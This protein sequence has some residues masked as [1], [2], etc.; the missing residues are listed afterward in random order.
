MALIAAAALAAPVAA[1]DVFQEAEIDDQGAGA[2][3]RTF[4]VE[5]PEEEGCPPA[6]PNCGPPGLAPLGASMQAEF[7]NL[8]VVPGAGIIGGDLLEFDVTI[9]N[10]STNPD[11]I[12]TAFAFQSK[13]SESPALDVMTGR[14]ATGLAALGAFGLVAVEAAAQQT[15]RIFGDIDTT[16]GTNPFGIVSGDDVVIT[17]TYINPGFDP[18]L[19]LLIDVFDDGTMDSLLSTPFT[20][21]DDFGFASGNGPQYDLVNGE[22]D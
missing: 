17:A 22:L 20:E 9:T 5:L 8:T 19:M 13:F 14:L 4:P 16:T 21:A 12:L 10:T 18:L 7:M 15:V 3:F 11:A 2:L 1:Q 6:N